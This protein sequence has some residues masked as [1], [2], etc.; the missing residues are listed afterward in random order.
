MSPRRTVASVAPDPC[1]SAGV[2]GA[3]LLPGPV[4][5]AGWIFMHG[6]LLQGDGARPGSG[7]WQVLAL[8]RT[9]SLA[10][11]TVLSR[12]KRSRTGDRNAPAAPR[13]RIGIAE[14][15]SARHR[16]PSCRLRQR[17]RARFDGVERR[18]RRQAGWGAGRRSACAVV[19]APTTARRRSH[20]SPQRKLKTACGTRGGH[21]DSTSHLVLAD[22]TRLAAAADRVRRRSSSSAKQRSRH[23][24]PA[25]SDRQLR[26]LAHDAADRTAAAE[27][28]ASESATRTAVPRQHGANKN[29]RNKNRRQ[30][31]DDTTKQ[32]HKSIT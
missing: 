3:L 5:V 18:W 28:A 9:A 24:R 23:R 17:G 20:H 2:A 6:A 29:R 11:S 21:E 4:R 1:R 15:A 14:A 10:R 30:Q 25:S 12:S 13:R 16:E 31:K 8:R 26:C 22:G 32:L 7:G 19:L 27:L